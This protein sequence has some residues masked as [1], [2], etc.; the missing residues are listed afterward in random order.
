MNKTCFFI[1]HREAGPEIMDLFAAETERPIKIP[2]DRKA[3]L[4]TDEPLSSQWKQH[5]QSLYRSMNEKSAHLRQGGCAL[6]L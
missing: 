2:Y 3:G 6:F 1:G 5:I 4:I